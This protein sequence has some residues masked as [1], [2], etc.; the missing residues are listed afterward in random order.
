MQHGLTVMIKFTIITATY[1]AEKFLPRLL[2]S[3][4]CQTY[5]LYEVIIQ[6]G[7]S[8]D[9]TLDILQRYEDRISLRSEPD[10]GIYDAWN[11]AAKRMTGDWAIFLGADDC[12]MRPHVLVRC[13]HYMKQLPAETDF[14]YGALIHGRNGSE[15]Y[16]VL[17][18]S[19]HKVYRIFSGDMGLP[20]S[21][22]FIRASLLREHA[23]DNAYKIAGDFDFAARLL[24]PYNIA[25]IPVLV[26]YMELGGISNQEKTR[27]ALRDER[28]KI[29]YRRIRPKAQE[30]VAACRRHYRH[31]DDF[32]EQFQ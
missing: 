18:R 23:F 17:N 16:Y 12:F 8:T 29:V 27:C 1:N 2:A 31:T 11:K 28:D 15:T 22:A 9:G 14:A 20:F 5:P 21:A 24:T 4:F 19:L 30:I 3:I 13:A 25:R 10:N 26:S 32:I 6:D 7:G